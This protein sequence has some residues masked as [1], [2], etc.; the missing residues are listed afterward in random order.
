MAKVPS[1]VGVEITGQIQE[2][3]TGVL[4]VLPLRNQVLEVWTEGILSFKK[5]LRT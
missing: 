2:Q 1:V 5:I 3:K 4:V